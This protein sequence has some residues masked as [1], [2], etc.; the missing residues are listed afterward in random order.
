LL[1]KEFRKNKSFHLLMVL[2]V[3][4][5]LFSSLIASHAFAQKATV[6]L[7]KY[8][9]EI[10]P[11]K[12]QVQKKYQLKLVHPYSFQLKTIQKSLVALKFKQKNILNIKKGRIFN[13]DLV[14]RLATLIQDKFTRV[15]SNQRVSFKIYNASRALYLQGDTFL[16]SEGLNWRITALRGIKWGIED[17]SVSGEPWVLVLQKEQAYKQRYWKGSTQV[18]QDIVNWV[19]FENV[20]PNPSRKLLEPAPNPSLMKDKIPSS[21]HTTSDIKKRLHLLKQLREENVITEKEYLNKR[22]AILDQL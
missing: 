17:F 3:Q 20:L 10:L 7:K 16:T 8:K 9:V 2:L 13:N 6:N 15:N 22:R 18:A 14:K 21:K 4:G 11:L 1:K 19:I 12:K 5:C